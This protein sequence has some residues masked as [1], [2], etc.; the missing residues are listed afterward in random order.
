MVSRR[1]PQKGEIWHVN[2]DPVEGREFKG[3]HY[4]LVISQ[5]ELDHVEPFPSNRTDMI[6]RG[7]IVRVAATQRESYVT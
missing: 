1:V 2:G 7:M 4:Y 3:P 5:R 6:I